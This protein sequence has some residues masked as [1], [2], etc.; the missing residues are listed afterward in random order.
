MNKHEKLKRICDEIGYDNFRDIYWNDD[1][2][3]TYNSNHYC[4]YYN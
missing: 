3:D 1:L 4:R 2:H